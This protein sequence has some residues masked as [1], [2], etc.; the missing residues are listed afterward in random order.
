M[1]IQGIEQPDVILVDDA[2]RLR[3]YDGMRD[4]ALE[5]YQDSQTVY[6]IDGNKEPYTVERLNTMYAYLNA[7]GELYFI[8]ALECGRYHPIMKNAGKQT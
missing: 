8:E 6:L 3:K 7:H 4:F 1:A 2:I 5:W